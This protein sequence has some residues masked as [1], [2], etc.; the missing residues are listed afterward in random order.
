MKSRNGHLVAL[1]ASCLVALLVVAACGGPVDGEAA[2]GSGVGG[3]S[4]ASS[5]L[6]NGGM[7]SAGFGAGTH[8]GGGHGSGD[9]GS[10]AGSSGSGTVGGGAGKPGAAG[11]SS[12]QI[13]PLDPLPVGRIANHQRLV[14]WLDPEDELHCRRDDGTPEQVP[15]GRFQRV[16]L[17]EQHGCAIDD[18]GGVT[19]FC[20]F[21]TWGQEAAQGC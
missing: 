21:D 19:C 8:S 20:V 2:A 5:G 1:Q 6:G 4:A 12:P 16:S 11:T 17:G 9:A 14:C 15:P 10:R 13:D 3:S 18:A 7:A